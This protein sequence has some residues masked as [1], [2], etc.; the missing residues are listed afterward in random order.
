MWLLSNWSPLIGSDTVHWHLPLQPEPQPSVGGIVHPSIPLSG[1]A[2]AAPVQI[3][4]LYYL[5]V[6]ALPTVYRE[7][8]QLAGQNAILDEVYDQLN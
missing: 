5:S 1:P 8:Y 2:G 3:R 4:L 6:F 7:W